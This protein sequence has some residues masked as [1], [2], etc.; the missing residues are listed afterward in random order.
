MY[1]SFELLLQG[2]VQTI[3]CLYQYNTNVLNSWKWAA[4]SHL[5]Q[6]YSTSKDKEQNPIVDKRNNLKFY[7]NVY[8]S[9]GSQHQTD[10]LM[11]LDFIEAYF[12]VY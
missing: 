10:V 4:D 6:V 9:L 2:H 11:L 12:D 7:F 1:T 3:A 8:L 5:E